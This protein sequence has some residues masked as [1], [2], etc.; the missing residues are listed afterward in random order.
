MPTLHIRCPDGTERT[1]E[2]ESEATVGRLDTNDL[3]LTEG[4]V[5]RSHARFYVEGGAVMVE[6]VGSANGTWVDGERIQ[7]PTPVGPRTQIVIGDYEISVRAAARG[8][9]GPKPVQVGGA[10]AGERPRRP[11]GGTPGA[12][13]Q[14]PAVKAARATRQMEVVKGRSGAPERPPPDALAKRPA[15]PERAAIG[16]GPVLRGLTGPWA[17]KTYPLRGKVVVGRVAGVNIQIEDES[18]SRRHA[19]LEKTPEGIV[20]RDLGSA[21]GTT[22]NG[23]PVEGDVVLQPGDVVS[24]GMIELVYEPGDE[25]AAAAPT[26]RGGGGRAAAGGAAG[27]SGGRKKLFIIGGAAVGV[28]LM[29]GVV[30]KA[31]GGTEEPVAPPPGDAVLNPLEVKAQVEQYLSE[32]RSY[33]TSELGNAPNWE[34]ANEA[35]QKALEL[36]PINSQVIAQIQKIA[37]EMECQKHFDA[38]KRAMELLREEQA[39]DEFGKI[40]PK[41]S[42]YRIVKPTARQ[43]IEAVKKRA[44]D[45]CNNYA[46]GNHW[47]LALQRC[48][49]YMTFACQNMDEDE[50]VPPV[51]YELDLWGHK[52]RIG[53]RPKDPQFLNLLRAREKMD[54]NAKLWTCPEVK[55]FEDDIVVDDKTDEFKKLVQ[56]K[57]KD[58]LM[59]E[60]IELYWNGKSGEAIVKL[61]KIRSNPDKV[62]LHQQADD[63]RADMG[64]VENLYKAG[65]SSL[66]ESEFEKAAEVFR[67]ALSVDEKLMKL[68]GTTRNTFYRHSIEVD[69]AKAAYPGG[70]VWAQRQDP[71][72]ACKI[73]RLGFSFYRGDAD[74]NKAIGYCS[75]QGGNRLDNASSCQDL[76]EVLDFATDGDGLK[77]K[78]AAKKAE[79]GCS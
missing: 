11:A 41:C 1:H 72:R 10:A 50:L 15:R 44:K 29:A 45:D 6:D 52:G 9:S 60:A 49:K 14:L 17:N 65:S 71:R 4:G 66:Q 57:F 59:Q 33:S 76:D 8:K 67:E 18:V 27:T 47:D 73:W 42:Y 23:Q 30:V 36:D 77:E 31:A 24:F 58:K 40:D 2:L 3:V 51:G 7:A 61:I 22:V 64:A 19:E 70:K 48:E 20:V 5:S 39:L 78:V 26:R 13:S 46:R 69:M 35:C 68:V 12:T 28:L 75:Q 21:N 56:S 34:K 74:L 32:C 54:P 43:A 63:L 79:L 55:M 62:S 16:S 25:E 53:W 37:L 38:G